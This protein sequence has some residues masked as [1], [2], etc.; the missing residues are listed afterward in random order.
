MRQTDSSNSFCGSKLTYSR[1]HKRWPH[2]HRTWLYRQLIA[3]VLALL[4]PAVT[5]SALFADTNAA[6]I[7]VPDNQ[8]D[9]PTGHPV[10]V[11]VLTNDIDDDND[12]VPSSVRILNPAD[13]NE[14]KSTLV[15]A[16]EGIWQVNST[17]GAITFTPCTGS[18]VP[19]ASCSAAFVNDPLPVEYVV[20]DGQGARSNPAIITITF[21]PDANIAPFAQNDSASTERNT[22][23]SID[24]LSNDSDPDGAL[25]PGTLTIFTAPAHGSA[26]IVAGAKIGYT[27]TDNY[28]G[29]DQLTYRI[30]DNGSPRLC[31]TAI[32]EI[33]VLPPAVNNPPIARN[34]SATLIFN[35]PKTVQVLNNDSDP[36]NMLDPASVTV[37]VAAAN[38]TATPLTGGSIR[39]EPDTDYNGSDSFS[40]Q[41]CD[42]GSP[43]NVTPPQ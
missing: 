25:R 37:T 36:E 4:L 6:P 23:V 14:R 42:S 16:G 9:Q 24:V 10:V 38:G 3:A 19:H 30:C 17:N 20:E 1:Q 32:V 39:Y 29:A 27:P 18:G 7:A 11:N 26:S 33:T 5:S 28:V 22:P 15:V 2:R 12:L 8:L 40:Y 43:S 35:T 13:L 31:S 21:D 34:D 41:V